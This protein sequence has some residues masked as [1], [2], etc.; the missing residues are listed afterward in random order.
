VRPTCFGLPFNVPELKTGRPSQF[1]FQ[2]QQCLHAQYPVT[3]IS[4]TTDFRL[5]GTS[6]RWAGARRDTHPVKQAG[7]NRAQ[8]NNLQNRS[9]VIRINPA[10]TSFSI[11]LIRCTGYNNGLRE[12]MHQKLIRIITLAALWGISVLACP[13]QVKPAPD[14]T[15]KNWLAL[16]EETATFYQSRRYDLAV[17]S[18]QS[19]L[20]HARENFGDRHLHTAASLYTLSEIHYDL[21]QFRKAVEPAKEALAI[22]TKLL[23][24]DDVLIAT[25]AN[26][27]AQIYQ[28]FGEYGMAKPLNDRALLIWRAKL[29]NDHPHVAVSLNNLGK[30]YHARSNYFQ[31]NALAAEKKGDLVEAERQHLKSIADMARAII[32]YEESLEILGKHLKPDDPNIGASYYNLAE[33][34]TL[35]GQYVKAEPFYRKA[36]KI[37]A[38]KLG[39]ESMHVVSCVHKLALTLDRQDK[40]PLAEKFYEV[41]VKMSTAG[42][43]GY[44][45]NKYSLIR[46]CEAFYSKIGNEEKAKAFGGQMTTLALEL[47]KIGREI[48]FPS[49]P[50]V[51]IA[52]KEEVPAP[53]SAPAPEAP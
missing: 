37:S 17:H 35:S 43:K 38:R 32:S 2:P 49:P 3:S 12:S 8:Q 9:G 7:I 24:L 11:P 33:A 31:R 30:I 42:F 21:G 41:A 34:Y 48:P 29:G 28:A 47:K 6:I 1:R 46:D 19:A 5:A 18:A 26:S 53:V 4:R 16:M 10:L 15:E 51:A 25:S 39:K 44:T 27:L 36:L 13:A 52:L 20:T 40:D 50:A 45:Q 22:R 23:V 14:E